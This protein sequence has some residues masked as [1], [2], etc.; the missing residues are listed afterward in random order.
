MRD[1]DPKA[2]IAG[3]FDRAAPTYEQTG[4][5]FYG[6][7]G[8]ALVAHAGITTGERVLDLGCGRGNVFFPAAAAVGPTGTVVGVDFAPVMRRLTTEAAKDLPWVRV[9]AGDAEYPDF[10][11]CSFDVVTAGFMIF[12]MPDPAAAVA[13]WAGLLRPGGRLAISTFAES[14]TAGTTFYADRAA[15]LAPFQRPEQALAGDAREE[16]DAQRDRV[17]GWF[18]RADLTGVTMTELTVRSHYP[19]ADAYWAWWLSV[20]ARRQLERVPPHRVPAARAAITEVLDKHLRHPGGGYLSE[21]PM[22]LTV[23]RRPG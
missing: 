2:R 5:E 20:G 13:R 3:V 14:M 11:P 8:R 4:V 12:F 16:H 23:A 1:V 15:A 6:P 18:D 10:P 19:S 7:P 17:R 9:T 22:R 21:T